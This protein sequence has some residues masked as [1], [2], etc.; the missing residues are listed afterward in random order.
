MIYTL[1]LNPTLDE[2]IFVDDFFVGG[3]FKANSTNV[4]PMGKG[5]S[6]ALTLREL[7]QQV[8]VL[9][10]IGENEKELYEEFL[11]S[12]DIQYSFI[13]VKGKTRSNK[14]ILDRPKN[15]ITHI[16]LP[17][18]EASPQNLD[19]LYSEISNKLQKDDLLCFSGSFPKG[20]TVDYLV[21]IKGLCTQKSVKFFMDSSGA[22]LTRIKELDPLFYKGNMVEFAEIY[23]KLAGKFNIDENIFDSM[24]PNEILDYFINIVRE[25]DRSKLNIV[26]LGKYGSV[27]IDN[28]GIVYAEYK[29]D[30]L[31][32]VGCGDA[33][34]GG[35]IFGLLNKKSL[36]ETLAIAT[37]CGVSNTEILGAG[38]IDKKRVKELKGAIRIMHKKL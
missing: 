30:A 24:G 17:G 27:A 11:K 26:T 2:L 4:F 28:E 10:L 38:I 23:P 19:D 8:H 25:I 18:F 33:F 22:P 32:T 13:T 37:S 14:S 20:I 36:V 34:L 3:T 29:T 6:V 15:T 21:K 35:L 12:K 7:G 16:R 5:I 9:S 1:L 31:Y